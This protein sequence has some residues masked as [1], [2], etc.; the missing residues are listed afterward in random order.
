MTTHAPSPRSCS[1]VA[2]ILIR[3]YTAAELSIPV[4]LG[5]HS[6]ATPGNHPGAGPQ[7]LSGDVRRVAFKFTHNTTTPRFSVGFWSLSGPAKRYSA[8]GKATLRRTNE[9]DQISPGNTCRIQAKIR[10]RCR[11][12]APL[13]FQL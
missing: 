12:L 6:R 4:L 3:K 11:N 2:N 1:G 8:S 9:R 10:L 7:R 5:A 13:A